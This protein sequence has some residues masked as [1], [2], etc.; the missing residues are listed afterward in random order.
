MN[1]GAKLLAGL[2]AERG[3]Q[4]L[5]AE[6]LGI[7]QG[8]LSKIA[9]AERVPGLDARRKLKALGIEMDAWDEPPDAAPDSSRV[10]TIPP[11]DGATGTEGH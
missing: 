4:K 10:T 11:A 5:L 7:D 3:S 2:L 9:S 8:Y 1:R 6:K